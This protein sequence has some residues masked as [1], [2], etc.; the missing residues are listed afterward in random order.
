MKHLK[1][2]AMAATLSLSATGAHA[3]EDVNLMTGPF[4][5]GSYVLGNAL[6][7]LSKRYSTDIVVNSSETPG[8]VFNAKTQDLNPGAKVNTM[9]AFTAGINYLATEGLRPFKAPMPSAKIIANYNL[10]SVWL[11]TFD[12]EI[13]TP[14]DLIGKTIALG[15]PPQILWTIE[16]MM[17]I[18]HGWGLTDQ[19]DI[20]RLGTKQAVRALLDGNVDAAIIGGYADPLTGTFA[21]SPQ[22]VELLGTGRDIY[23]IPWGLD[24]VEAVRAEGM[25]IKSLTLPEGAIAGI[26]KPHEVFFDA[27]SWVAYPEMDENLAYQTTRLIIEQIDG[28]AEY[29]ALGKLMSPKS[30]VFG[31]GPDDFHPG[32]LR[33]YRE[34]GLVE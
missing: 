10:G 20:E 23:H 2:L 16:P 24:A 30:L 17:I 8:L 19:I 12:P 15:R 25:S 26:D 7:Q 6:E 9:M 32:A 27:I 4:G 29:H 1:S 31:W 22:T 5:T 14:Q 18:E 13:R 11:A 34:A 21:P 3:A 28:F 33:A